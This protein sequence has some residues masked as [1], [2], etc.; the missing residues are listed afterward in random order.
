L[1]KWR[2]IPISIIQSQTQLLPTVSSTATTLT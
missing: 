1:T 2:L